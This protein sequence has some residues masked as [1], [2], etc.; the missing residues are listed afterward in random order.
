MLLART[1]RALTDRFHERLAEHHLEP[2]RPA[3]GFVFRYLADNTD[4]T[5]VDL[6]VHLG[7]TKQ[8]AAKTVAELVEWSYVRRAPHPTDRRAH[9][10]TLTTKGRDYLRLADRLWAEL[11]QEFAGTVGETE[12]T[13]LRAAL[14]TYL[15]HTDHTGLRP[16]W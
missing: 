14:T 8:A 11:D 6:A 1:F 5:A 7:V 2:L 12:F 13:T 4:P 9:T 3:H 16:V 10:L 15:A